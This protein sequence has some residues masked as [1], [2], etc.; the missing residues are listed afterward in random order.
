MPSITPPPKPKKFRVAPP[1]VERKFDEKMQEIALKE[2]EREIQEEAAARGLG[3]VNLVG[4]PISP[5]AMSLIPEPRARKAQTICFLRSGA[6]IR[7]ATVDPDNPDGQVIKEELAKYYHANVQVYLTTEH[8]F[9]KA[10]EL[11]KR[12]PTPKK[13]ASGV[14]ITE[15]D[16]ERF[17]KEISSS[18]DLSQRIHDIPLTQIFTMILAGATAARA[19]DVHIE[20]ED[21]DV[22]VRFRVDGV[23]R[24]VAT[25]PKEA[26]QRIISRIKLLAQLKINI[27][28]IPQDGNITLALSSGKI[29]VRVST[30]PTTYGESVALRML[31]SSGQQFGFDD[32]GLRG[33]AYAKLKAEI[34]RPNG[35][36]VTSGPT[37]SGKTT[38]LYAIL[39]TMNTQERK[40][41][42]LE[43]PIEYKLDGVNQSQVDHTKGYTFAKGLR[44]ILRQDPDII[45]VGEIRDL[46]TAEIAIQAALTGHL[47]LSTIH[48]NNAAGAIPRFLSMGV[49]PFLLAPALNTIM[50]QRLVRRICVHCKEP[51]TIDD[52]TTKKIHEHLDK[53]PADERQGKDFSKLTFFKGK[54][55]DQCQRNGYFDRIGIYE[56]FSMDENIEKI[57]LSGQVSEYQMQDVAIAQGMVTMVQDGLMKALDGITTVEEV[58]RVAE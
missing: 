56:L 54:G 25:L 21:Q 7:L 32:L 9:T 38:T 3:F 13:I 33:K 50:A 27:E 55:C 28:S 23:L 31:M 2:K 58:F 40:I 42:T 6:E 41:I 26:W 47:V 45:M 14:E 19:S 48:T 24:D 37:G 43:D 53:L 52:E 8:S 49:K 20:A 51:V 34:V 1:E 35:M 46:E 44:S 12:I 15:A 39:R 5:E 29:D 4:F 36:V 17:Q 11:Y 57:V 30:I 16:L 22:K 18:A 10:I